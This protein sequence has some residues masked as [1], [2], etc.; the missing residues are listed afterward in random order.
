[1]FAVRIPGP[2]REAI[3]ERAEEAGISEAD[4]VREAMEDFLEEGSRTKTEPTR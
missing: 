4:L 3:A 1:M 2:L